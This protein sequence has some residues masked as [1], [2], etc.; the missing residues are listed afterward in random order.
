VARLLEAG[1]TD[2]QIATALGIAPGTATVHV[3]HVLRKLGLRSRWQVGEPSI[4]ST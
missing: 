3:H 1:Y 4:R 2:R